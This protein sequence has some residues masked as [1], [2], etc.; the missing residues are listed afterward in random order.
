ML[1]PFSLLKAVKGDIGPEQLT[2]ILSAM[3]IEGE[4]SPVPVAEAF[5]EFERVAQATSLPGANL[6]RVKMVMK[7]GQRLEGLLVMVQS[8]EEA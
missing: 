5:P 2:E 3:G 6:V 7:Q 4:F 1:N 8:V